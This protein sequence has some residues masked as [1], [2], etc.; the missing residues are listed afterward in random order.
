MDATIFD[1]FVLAL[2]IYWS[3]YALDYAFWVI[4]QFIDPLDGEGRRWE[5]LGDAVIIIS[6]LYLFGPIPLLVWN[7]IKWARN[8]IG[9]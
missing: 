8:L 6:I 9:G 1:T 7:T 5:R 4:I 2:N 3:L